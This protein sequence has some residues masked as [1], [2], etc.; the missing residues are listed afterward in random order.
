MRRVFRKKKD[1]Q[2]LDVGCGPGMQTVQLAEH[3]TGANIKA[4]DYYPQFIDEL[5]DLA[6]ARGVSKRIDPVEGSMFEMTFAEESFDVLWSE[7]AVYIIGFE[8]GLKEWKRFLKPGGFMAVSEISWLTDSRPAELE[9]YW[10]SEYPGIDT[11]AGKTGK[12]QAAGYVPIGTYVF[13]P[14]D[15]FEYYF[16]PLMERISLCRG[17]AER[18]RDNSAELLG[19]LEAEE[20]EIEL[21]RKYSEYYSYAFYIM[22]RPGR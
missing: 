22:R 17:I 4:L 11:L 3:F 9:A 12:I 19:I 15:W 8:R 6:A 21:F 20:H 13:P 5:T 7:G 18:D 10:S 14:Q 16:D 1:L 2:V